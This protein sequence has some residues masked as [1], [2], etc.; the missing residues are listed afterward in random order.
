MPIPRL[1]RTKPMHGT[2]ESPSP[3]GR[4]GS[5][6]QAK[7]RKRPSR[8]TASPED[9]GRTGL[10][11]F[12]KSAPPPERSCRSDR[13]KRKKG[14]RSEN[15]RIFQPAFN[16][17]RINEWN[18]SSR[19]AKIRTDCGSHRVRK[20]DSLNRKFLS[21]TIPSAEPLSPTNNT[22]TCGLRKIEPALRVLFRSS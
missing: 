1:R 12:G 10:S 9:S 5:S 14:C 22:N 3:P 20:A 15:H 6:W 18:G 2:P 21:E 4:A 11:A 7:P 16:S 8:P 13:P 19:S 17:R